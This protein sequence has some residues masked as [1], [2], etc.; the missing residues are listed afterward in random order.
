MQKAMKNGKRGR[1][2]KGETRTALLFAA[3]AMIPMLV[4][5]IYPIFRSLFISLTD[6][7]YISPTYNFVWFE[8]YISIFDSSSFVKSL[9]TTV[10]FALYTV[11]PSMAIGL[12][13]RSCFR[14]RLK[15]TGYTARCC[16]APGSPRRSPSPSYGYGCL[17]WTTAF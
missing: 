10:L 9:G 1:L 8:N 2:K 3:P 7:D 12:G 11:I 16:S 6:W 14:S 17:T 13:W 4:F 15:A 5:W